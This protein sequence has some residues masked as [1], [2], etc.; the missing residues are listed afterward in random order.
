MDKQADLWC[1]LVGRMHVVY[2]PGIQVPGS[3][4]VLLFQARRNDL[5]PYTKAHARSIAHPLDDSESRLSVLNAYEN[6]RRTIAPS[7]LTNAQSDVRRKD[8]HLAK[9]LAAAIAMH[10]HRLEGMGIPY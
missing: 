10:R 7:V 3:R 4:W 5:I 1:A 6:W 8:Q 2:D 9:K